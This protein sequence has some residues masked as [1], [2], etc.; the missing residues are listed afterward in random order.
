MGIALD[1]SGLGQGQVE[2]SCVSGNE[3]TSPIKCENFL[4]SWEL[5]RISGRTLLHSHC[6]CHKPFWLRNGQLGYRGSS[7]DRKRFRFFYPKR[8]ARPSKQTIFIISGY[9]WLVPLRWY[10]RMWDWP[11]TS[12]SYKIKKEWSYSPANRHSAIACKHNFT[13]TWLKFLFGAR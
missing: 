6:R 2:D 3:L 1:W 9:R 13:S 7:P 4:T 5:A 10:D 12:S 11:L 8:R